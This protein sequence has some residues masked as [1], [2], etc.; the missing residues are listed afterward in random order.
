MV[1]E[2]TDDEIWRTHF[3][4]AWRTLMFDKL[5]FKVQWEGD[6]LISPPEPFDRQGR[7]FNSLFR[8]A[9]IVPI[10][11]VTNIKIEYVDGRISPTYALASGTKFGLNFYFLK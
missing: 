4:L 2:D 3:E 8:A 7:E 1:E 9:V 5:T 10:K 6:L 11:S